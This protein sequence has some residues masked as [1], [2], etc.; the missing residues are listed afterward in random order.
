MD[1]VTTDNVIL[2]GLIA[3]DPESFELVDNPFTEEPY[4]IGLTKGDDEFRTFIND[5]LEVA[6]DDGT[7]A[8]AWEETAGQFAGTP[9][10][11]SVDRY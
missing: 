6:Y 3:Q 10:P 7:W 8:A 1:S 2:L 5:V 9:E 11:P 4:G